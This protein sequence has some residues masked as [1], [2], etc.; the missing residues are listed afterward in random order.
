MRIVCLEIQTAVTV[1][2]L[3]NREMFRSRCSWWTRRSR[4]TSTS[5]AVIFPPPTGRAE[6]LFVDKP[7]GSVSLLFYFAWQRAKLF[8]CWWKKKKRSFSFLAVSF[9]L[10]G[11]ATSVGTQKVITETR[12]ARRNENEMEKKR[13]KGMNNINIIGIGP[14]CGH[15]LHWYLRPPPPLDVGAAILPD[16]AEPDEMAMGPVAGGDWDELLD[17]V[18]RGA[19]TPPPP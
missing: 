16:A 5:R 9:D 11:H 1:R 14:T 13:E 4:V 6:K 19:P 8:V 15:I 2:S 7:N 17:V 10:A 3:K 18:D 12:P